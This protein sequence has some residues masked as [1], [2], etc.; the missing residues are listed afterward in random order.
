MGRPKLN[1]TDAERKVRR[2]MQVS[3]A[4]KRFVLKDPVRALEKRK[5]QKD[6]YRQEHPEYCTKQAATKRSA[7]LK[8]KEEERALRRKNAAKEMREQA[9]E[10]AM[11]KKILR[12]F[13]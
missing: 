3:A 10:P 13:K 9:K 12:C 1:L 7:R 11:Q 4:Y 2:A 5:N 8:L 6:I